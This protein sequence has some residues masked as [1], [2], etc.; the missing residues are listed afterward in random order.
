MALA[1]SFR[2]K[3]ITAARN[4][5]GV[6]HR[7]GAADSQ[8]RKRTDVSFLDHALRVHGLRLESVSAKSRGLHHRDAD[9][10]RPGR[11]PQTARRAGRWNCSA[12]ALR[13]D[14]NQGE[15]AGALTEDEA[16]AS[17]G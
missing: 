11:R 4:G 5:E 10:G 12:A 15:H 13:K 6:R 17:R 1:E 2:A 3:L 16:R 9:P 7:D 14:L 8:L